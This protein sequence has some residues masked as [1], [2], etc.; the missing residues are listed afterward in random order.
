M[1]LISLLLE[2]GGSPAASRLSEV[3]LKQA[4]SSL[5]GEEVSP[6]LVVSLP[7]GRPSIVEPGFHIGWCSEPLM[8][9]PIPPPG[10]FTIAIEISIRIS[11]CSGG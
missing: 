8:G 10:L 6:A 4:Y 2:R 3:F 1:Y 9:V 7:T 11:V 5:V